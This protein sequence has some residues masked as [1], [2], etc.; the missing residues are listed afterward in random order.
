LCQQIAGEA[1]C[2]NEDANSNEDEGFE[3][4]NLQTCQS[5]HLKY[6]LGSKTRWITIISLCWEGN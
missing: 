5:L 4:Q 6:V 1:N 2:H 3:N